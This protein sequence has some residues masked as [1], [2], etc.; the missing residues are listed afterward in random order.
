MHPSLRLERSVLQVRSGTELLTKR[1]QGFYI[2]NYEP[3]V[4]ESLLVVGSLL[5]KRQIH[6]TVRQV[7][8]RARTF[9]LFHPECL[10]IEFY[11]SL[12]ILRDNS[13]VTNPRHKRSSF[14]TFTA[15]EPII[16]KAVSRYPPALH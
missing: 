15:N 2:I 13:Q 11:K 12:S 5:D 16:G 4:I 8:C 3:E 6:V 7:Y 1:F 14:Q 9:N 10:G